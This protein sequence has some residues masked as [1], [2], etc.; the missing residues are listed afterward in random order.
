V[1]DLV[2]A[3][4]DTQVATLVVLVTVQAADRGEAVAMDCDEIDGADAC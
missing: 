2:G 3:D 4:F 1:L